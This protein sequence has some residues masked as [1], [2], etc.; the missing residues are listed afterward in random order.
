MYDATGT[1]MFSVRVSSLTISPNET[2]VNDFHKTQI[3]HDFISRVQLT[4]SV[5][6]SPSFNFQLFKQL[7]NELSMI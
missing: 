3:H 7:L 4:I 1:K 2:K 6:C 5:F